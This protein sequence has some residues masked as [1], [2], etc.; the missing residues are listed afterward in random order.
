MKQ[1]KHVILLSTIILLSSCVQ[2]KHLKTLI[3]KVDMQHIE[4][5]SNPMVHGQFTS[6]S[7]DIG[8]P[9][10][11][12]DNDGIYE[13]KAEIEAAQYSIQFKFKNN[14]T[15]ELEGQ[16]NR[17]VTLEYKPETIIYECKFDNPK[18]KQSNS[19]TQDQ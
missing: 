8:V 5:V 11:D 19:K 4:H 15:F 14:D 7:W 10:T 12:I 17:F 16:N 6:P 1:L 18:G 2:E 3:F 9:L 13:G